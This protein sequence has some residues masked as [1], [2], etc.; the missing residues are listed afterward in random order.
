MLRKHSPSQ[1]D[2]VS[3]KPLQLNDEIIVAY[4]Q[5]SKPIGGTITKIIEQRPER[6]IYKDES[7]RRTW[8]R[9]EFTINP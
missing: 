6:G 2:Y 4:D 8:Q 1:N 9:V 5:N 7:L 3:T